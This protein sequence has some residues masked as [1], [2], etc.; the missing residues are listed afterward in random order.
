MILMLL[1]FS[2]VV[3]AMPLAS[4]EQPSTEITEQMSGKSESELD[5]YLLNIG[6]T[7]DRLQK[8]PYGLKLN[9]VNDGAIKLVETREVKGGEASPFGTIPD[10]D[11]TGLIELNQLSNTSDGK[12]RFKI[13]FHWVWNDDTMM[14]LTDKVSIS[15]DPNFI[16]DTATNGG[17]ACEH[18]KVFAPTGKY[19]YLDNCGGTP[20]DIGLAGAYWNVDIKTGTTDAGYVAMNVVAKNKT[21]GTTPGTIITKYV[22]DTSLAFGFNVDLKI[23]GLSFSSSGSFDEKPWQ[24]SFKY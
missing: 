5:D 11:I 16:S 6:Y 20:G 9:I 22:H 17:Y 23:V 8:M 24:H 18:Y 4:K 7:Q 10:S 15:Y 12:K 2:T 14:N 19:E 1:T 3:S 13:T 21:T